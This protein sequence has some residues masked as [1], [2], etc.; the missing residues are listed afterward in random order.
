MA[1]AQA[2]TESPG[3]PHVRTPSAGTISPC[4]TGRLGRNGV[5]GSFWHVSCSYHGDRA[6]G[7]R[8]RDGISPPPWLCP[9]GPGHPTDT[10]VREKEHVMR[11]TISTLML[12]LVTMMLSGCI[13]PYWYD[14]G[15]GGGGPR[16]GGHRD[17]GRH[18]GG[19][20]H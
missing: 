18:G 8:G 16:G 10:E 14:D 12:L 6:W 7:A 11:K 17:N 9:A 20:R 13:F 1:V 15:Y 2:V 4:N 19:G 3:A 5:P